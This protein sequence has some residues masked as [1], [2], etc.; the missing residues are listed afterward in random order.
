MIIKSQT[1]SK[2]NISNSGFSAQ[3]PYCLV[4]GFMFSAY[5]SV[6]QTFDYN[7]MSQNRYAVIDTFWKFNL[8]TILLIIHRTHDYIEPSKS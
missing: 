3:L 7:R 1:K 4:E 2:L 6:S 8:Y 5:T